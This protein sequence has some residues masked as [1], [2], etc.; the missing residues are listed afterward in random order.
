MN[1]EEPVYQRFD[2][3]CRDCGADVVY[4]NSVKRHPEN[5]RCDSC[6]KAWI[7]EKLTGQKPIA[8]PVT[9]QG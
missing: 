1:K 9:G 6:E 7:A 5:V 4:H 3:K 8:C 2:G